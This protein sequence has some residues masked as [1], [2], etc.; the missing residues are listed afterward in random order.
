MAEGSGNPSFLRSSESTNASSTRK[1]YFFSLVS[2][3]LFLA[4]CFLLP[5]S[6]FLFLASCF[7]LLT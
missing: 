4:S 5:V 2:C 7:L 6:C 1:R 3:F